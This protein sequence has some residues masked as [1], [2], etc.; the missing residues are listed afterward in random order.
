MSNGLDDLA[1]R[2]RRRT[3][4]PPKHPRSEQPS[5]PAAPDQDEPAQEE[6]PEASTPQ[7]PPA[8]PA[9]APSPVVGTGAPAAP[10]TEEQVKST[11]ASERRQLNVGVP[12]DLKLHRRAGLYAEDHGLSRQDQVAIALDAWLRERGY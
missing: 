5:A 9:P 3:A 8:T 2:R 1:G 4:P 10:P 7:A 11:P 12:R 6:Q